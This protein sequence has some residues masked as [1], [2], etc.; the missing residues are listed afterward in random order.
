MSSAVGEKSAI[1]RG[2]V[3]RECESAA[4]LRRVETA[5]SGAGRLLLV[6]G[7][8]GIGKSALLRDVLDRADLGP[9]A[10]VLRADCRP[11]TR[12]TPYG[13]VRELLAPL[14]LLEPVA[15]RP[16]LLHSG[17]RWAVPALA[18]PS[19][20]G[21]ERGSSSTYAVMHGLYWL[22]VNIM[23]SGPLV[24]AIDDAHQADLRS[25]H[26]LG[27]LL[28][29]TQDM[30]L[31]VVLTT[32]TPAP[33]PVAGLAAQ[34]DA[35]VLDLGPLPA[36]AIDR[37]VGDALGEEPDPGFLAECRRLSGGNPL[38]L[39]QVLA[40]LTDF[41]ASDR[42][43]LVADLDVVAASVAGRLAAHPEHVTRVARAVAVLETG[44]TE[45]VAA[46]SGVPTTAVDSAVTLLRADEL[47]TREGDQ[48][49]HELVRDGVLAAMPDSEVV[50]TRALAARLLDDAGRAP[51]VVA[52]HLLLL[53]RIDAPWMRNVLSAAAD[54]AARRGDPDAGVRCLARLVDVDPGD[55]VLRA[56]LAALLAHGEPLIALTHLRKALGLTTNPRLRAHIA[57]QLG[58]VAL[59]VQQTPS[60]VEVLESAL[61]ALE[62]ELGPD[63]EPGDAELAHRVRA[64]LLLCGMDKKDTVRQIQHRAGAMAEPRGDTPA[65]R[66]LLAML[67]VVDAVA[68]RSAEQAAHRARRSLV[69]DEADGDGWTAFA[70]A[71]VLD[72]VGELHDAVAAMDRVI[73]RSREDGAAWTHCLGLSSR[74][75]M[76]CNAGEFAEAAVDAQLALESARQESWHGRTVQPAV[77]V[78]QALVHQGEARRA[79]DLLVSVSRPDLDDFLVE[80]HH[81]RLARASAHAALDDV[82][83]AL[84]DL[85]WCGRSLADAGAANPLFVP[86]W[87]EAALLLADHG[88]VAEATRLVDHGEELTERWNVPKARG[89]VLLT[90]AAVCGPETA[91][92]LLLES[93]EVLDVPCAR[94]DLHRAEHRLGRVLIEL[95]D[96]R[97]A[98]EHLRRAVDLATRCGAT[99]AASR[100]RALLVRAGG[101][102]R[103]TALTRADVLTGSERRVAGLAAAGATNR[104][105]AE[106]LFVTPRTVEV[107]LTKA[108]RKLGISGR[109]ELTLALTEPGG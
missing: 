91:A 2:L 39:S 68:G 104:E 13:A 95:D 42:S 62:A 79:L 108:Y 30:P 4:A 6:Q 19:D 63:P 100:S 26:W 8:A 90:R 52:A 33:D 89:L 54:D 97:G 109:S 29:R 80:N 22:A 3:G 59:A 14:D 70:A 34:D 46:L 24:L 16:A 55:P 99:T 85:L 1:R 102:M 58:S 56:R 17:A 43:R 11:S 53:P 51:E 44:D 78:A 71:M 12:D 28:R 5:V 36:E 37:L 87:S 88:R 64:V 50:H 21:V 18:P 92:G 49:V 86:W 74:A 60:A 48:F 81:F 76:L 72:L 61:E 105:I 38:V 40:Q 93:V 47:L 9:G 96:L 31:C 10:T 98:R 103:H 69:L 66:Q 23:A 57:V 73:A 45:L 20:G 84:E 94:Y 106:A 25:L 67:A 77:G 75:L 101:R 35:A 32:R 82:E 27:Y 65:E 83:K 41:P 7:P 15:T 107:H